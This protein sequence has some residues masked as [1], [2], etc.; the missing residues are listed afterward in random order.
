[1]KC[2][3]RA[4]DVKNLEPQKAGHKKQLGDQRVKRTIF[5]YSD[6]NEKEQTGRFSQITGDEKTL[7]AKGREDTH[8][9]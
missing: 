6:E 1:M 9:F 3:Q 7:I 5:Q 2:V 8:R 4:I